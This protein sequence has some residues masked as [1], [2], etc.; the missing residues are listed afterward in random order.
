[1]LYKKARKN[2]RKLHRIIILCGFI[3]AIFIFLE[4]RLKPVAES[5]SEMQAK[6]LATEI[7][8]QSVADIIDENNITCEQ[9][10]TLSFSPDNRITAVSSDTIV[11]NKLKNAVTLRI[12]DNISGIRNRRVD[13]PL[14]TIIG[15]ELFNGQGPS[16]PLFISLSG[17]VES[18]FESTFESG[19]INQTV[20]KLS[21]NIKAEI[22]V[23]MPLGSYSTNVDTSVLV[24]ETVIVGDVPSGMIW[25]NN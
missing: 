17:N 21:V 6:A 13:I 8:N 15:G 24:G 11:T 10:E 2:K 12:Q 3:S 25:R 7:I 4:Y 20:H 5:I 9:L 1:M 19:G 18:D 16:I 14:G 23:L 22:T